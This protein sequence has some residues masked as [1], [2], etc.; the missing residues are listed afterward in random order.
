M[1]LSPPL[2]PE[3]PHQ[4]IERH[5]KIAETL[6]RPHRRVLVHT[7]DPV[8][9][10]C[11]PSSGREPVIAIALVKSVGRCIEPPAEPINERRI[12]LARRASEGTAADEQAGHRPRRRQRQAKHHVM[13]AVELA[14]LVACSNWVV[15]MVPCQARRPEGGAEPFVASLLCRYRAPAFVTY[16]MATEA[17]LFPAGCMWLDTTK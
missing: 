2:H 9:Q 15:L 1:Q 6:R 13:T 7:D 12:G 8:D 3:H 14:E 10:E 5:A 4:R 17:W 16:R 11:R